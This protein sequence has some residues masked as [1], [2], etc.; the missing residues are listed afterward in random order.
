MI[1]DLFNLI[2]TQN[3]EEIIN[4]IKKSKEINYNFKFNNENFFIEYV[5]ESNILN[6][7]KRY[8]VKIYQL[9]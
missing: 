9:I 2:K 7:L 6:L 1:K 5:I 3:Y 8:L 4:K